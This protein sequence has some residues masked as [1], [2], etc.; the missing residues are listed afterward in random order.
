MLFQKN[1]DQIGEAPPV[2]DRRC[3]SCEL[4]ICGETNSNGR[5]FYMA[6]A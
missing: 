6:C 2:S 5:C 3:F 1:F 4:D